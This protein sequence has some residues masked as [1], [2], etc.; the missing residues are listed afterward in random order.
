MQKYYLNK[1]SQI[2]SG[3]S[4]RHRIESVPDGECLVIQMKDI[5]SDYSSIVGTPDSISLDGIGSSQLLNNGD[6]LFMAKG[7][8]NF[9]TLYQSE[10]PAIAVSLFFIIRP[11][12]TKVLPEY[13][14]WFINSSKAQA[15]FGQRQLGT[16]IKNIRKD[17]L[18]QL[19]VDVPEMSKQKQIAEL[20]N[21]MHT[22]KYLTQEYLEKKEVYLNQTMLNLITK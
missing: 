11:D 7:N 4:F 8:N 6:I 3:K 5:S 17:A 2:D 18:A 13:L 9:A 16:S 1:I 10:Q 20:N 14:T 19:E 22:E 15:Y 21:L 12:K